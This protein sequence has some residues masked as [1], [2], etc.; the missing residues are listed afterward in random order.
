MKNKG[1]SHYELAKKVLF[2]ASK[3]LTV[4]EITRE[5]CAQN[6]IQVMDSTIG[7]RVRELREDLEKLGGKVLVSQ[8]RAGS[9]VHEF[10][11]VDVEGAAA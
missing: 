10:W 5:V 2:A 4:Y 6:N 8:K 1:P 7:R 11:V 9:Q 3:P